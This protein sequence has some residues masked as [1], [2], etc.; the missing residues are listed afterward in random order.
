MMEQKSDLLHCQNFSEIKFFKNSHI[1]LM[2]VCPLIKP[3]GT[4][5]NLSTTPKYHVRLQNNHV[6]FFF[7]Q[8]SKQ[9]QNQTL[10][11]KC[12]YIPSEWTVSARRWSPLWHAASS[13]LLRTPFPPKMPAN[14][15]TFNRQ[16]H[17][18][19]MYIQRWSLQ[20]FYISNG[21]ATI[22]CAPTVV[23]VIYV[24]ILDVCLSGGLR[25]NSTF[26]MKLLLL[27]VPQQWWSM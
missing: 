7:P 24:T 17:H 27:D 11:I 21:A 25:N 15:K 26:K 4:L 23:I 6:S 1:L 16:Q 20:Q 12:S 18:T 8:A 19:G 5:T 10:F 3:M 2:F 13:G 22:R 9:P 14:I